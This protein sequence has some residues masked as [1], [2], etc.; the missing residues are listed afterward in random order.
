MFVEHTCRTYSQFLILA[1]SVSWAIF[2]PVFA[3]PT[4]VEV[5]EAKTLS[6][7]PQVETP[8]RVVSL[9]QSS[10]SA[11]ITS[12]VKTIPVNVGDTVN[13]GDVL[14]TLDCESFVLAAD[15]QRSGIG[16]AQAVY[17]QAKEQL[18]RLSKVGKAAATGTVRDQASSAE[19]ARFELEGRGYEYKKAQLDVQRCTVKAPLKGVVL[20]RLT[21]VGQVTPAGQPVIEIMDLEN[22]EVASYV[23]TFNV[24]GL[25]AA[26]EIFFQYENK[27][28]PVKIK[29]VVKVR[30]LL[31][32]TQEARL[33]FVGEMA[34]P[35]TTGKVVWHEVK[36]HLPADFL[37]RRAGK[38]GVMII[39]NNKAK[40]VYLPDAL[41]GR[42]A[43]I[44]FPP[45]TLVVT[46][47][48]NSLPEGTDVT[49]E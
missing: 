35:G 17:N 12:V 47:G 48:R 6:I 42:P 37:V 44:D 38:L 14:M 23:Q 1:L 32:R 40:F 2:R 43:R 27:S 24:D 4:T 29:A 34:L 18:T 39:E 26:K 46:K 31:T 8:A 49:V 25:N 45:E 13:Q 22:I 11:E 10:I 19:V 41:E 33:G 20:K 21:N 16:R 30:D 36:S 15:M 7:Y 28:F 9:N 5:K 3:A